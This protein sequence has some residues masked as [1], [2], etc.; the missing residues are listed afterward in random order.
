MRG[1]ALLEPGGFLQRKCSFVLAIGA[2]AQQ[3][4]VVGYRLVGTDINPPLLVAPDGVLNGSLKVALNEHFPLNHKFEPR[5]RFFVLSKPGEAQPH[6][7]RDCAGTGSLRRQNHS[8]LR[9]E[10]HIFACEINVT[11]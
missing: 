5:N 8:C 6:Q 1:S 7:E 11:V 3:R 10:R 2:E 4:G 9:C